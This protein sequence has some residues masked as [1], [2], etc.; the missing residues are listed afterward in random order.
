M[1]AK[2]CPR[3]SAYYGS[4]KSKTCPQCFAVLETIDDETAGELTATQA[5]IERTPEYQEAKAADDER[6]QEQS[7]GACLGVLGIILA[8]II[9]IVAV[10]VIGVHRHHQQGLLTHKPRITTAP[11]PLTALPVAAATL[12]DV[13]PPTIGAF[14]RVSSDQSVMLTGT[15]TPIF[16]SVYATPNLPPL[17][18]YAIPAG[19]PTT[20]E[21]QF[22]QGIALAVQMGGQAGRTPLFFSTQYWRFAVIAAPGQ[23]TVPATFRD[24][25]A[26]HFKT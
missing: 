7:F 16:H 9:L 21:D 6:F 8:T 23:E 1:P 25:L 11:E 13:M 14:R 19:L 12:E 4:L 3:C 17:E 10:I 18:V 2:I 15:L 26:A 20:Q 5:Q 22:R 24:A